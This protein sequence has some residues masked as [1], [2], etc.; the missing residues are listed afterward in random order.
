MLNPIARVRGWALMPVLLGLLMP[1]LPATGRHRTRP[2]TRAAQ[3]KRRRTLWLA[4]VGVDLD[5]RNIHAG[6]A[7]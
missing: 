4:T 7:R 2:A 1:A 5:H 3:R 6:T